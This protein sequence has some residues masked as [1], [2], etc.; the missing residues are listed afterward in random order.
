MMIVMFL[1]MHVTRQMKIQE[2]LQKWYDKG[3]R[4]V[5]HAE[6]DGEYSFVLEKQ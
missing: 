3:Y 4:V 2:E 5:S 6:D 1:R